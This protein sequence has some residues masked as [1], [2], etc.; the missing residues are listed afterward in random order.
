VRYIG[1]T[2]PSTDT[3]WGVVAQ[4]VNRKLTSMKVARLVRDETDFDDEGNL[5]RYVYI[6]QQLMSVILAEQGLV[7]ADI[8]EPNSDFREE[9]LE[10]EARA[11]EAGLGLWGAPPTAT[12]G[13]SRA[14]TSTPIRTA[15]APSP[16]STP[17]VVESPSP[18]GS[19]TPAGESS[20]QADTPEPESATP[21]ATGG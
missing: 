7:R 14:V 2:A 17:T 12:P 8:T 4:E 5:L 16:V 13:R 15:T 9:I 20:T 11:R 19:A 18:A 21:E 3:A 1:V 10:A 6:G